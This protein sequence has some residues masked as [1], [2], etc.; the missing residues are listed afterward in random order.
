M[1][2]VDPINPVFRQA[3][4]PT[5]N[6]LIVHTPYAQD[7][8]DW[9]EIKRNIEARASDI[10]VRIATNR[11]PNSV[12][13][14]W[15]ATR[16][17]LVFSPFGLKS[18][19]PKGG[20]VY[21]GQRISK[22]TQIERLA[23]LGLPVPPTAK[24]ARNL[25]LDPERWGRYVVVKPSHGGQGRDVRL[26]QISDVAHRYDELTLNDTQEIVIQPYI[27][28]SEQGFPT[29]YRVLTLFGNVLIFSA[30]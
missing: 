29:E 24:L 1:T 20:K 11:A 18:Y 27:E 26:L 2:Y 21:A 8:S 17:S 15:Q 5:R 25:S 16:P 23:H 3:A 9:L 12:T 28:H 7:L 6:L 19:R 4:E 14:R 30:Q 10:E 13:R 22:L